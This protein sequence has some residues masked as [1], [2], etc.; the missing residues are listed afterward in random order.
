MI[1]HLPVGELHRL[2][3]ALFQQFQGNF[4]L[5]LGEIGVA[6]RYTV[7]I[8][9]LDDFGILDAQIFADQPQ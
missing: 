6:E 8:G 1:D 2:V 9:G 5:A 7:F 3:H 4:E